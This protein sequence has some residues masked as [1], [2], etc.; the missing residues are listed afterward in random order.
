LIILMRSMMSYIRKYNSR[1]LLSFLL[2]LSVFL[3][4]LTKIVDTDAWLHLSL[5]REIFNQG[6]LP[7]TE[8]LTYPNI[9]KAFSYGSW[10]FGL[11]YYAAY[12]FFD[13]YGVILLKAFSITAAFYFLLKDSLLPYKNHLVSIIILT[14]AVIIARGRFVERPDT[15]LM[16]FLAFSMYALNAF[17]Y[18]NKRYIYALPL[19]HLVWANSHS[20]VILSFAVFLPYIA[21]NI[22]AALFIDSDNDLRARSYSR[23]K[24]ILLIFII[25]FAASLINPVFIKIYTGSTNVIESSWWQDEIVELAKPTWGKQNTPYILAPLLL[26]SFILNWAAIWLII[27]RGKA[28]GMRGAGSRTVAEF[29]LMSLIH[30][31]VILPFIVLSFKAL[32]FIFIL[33]IVSAPIVSRNTSHLFSYLSEQLEFARYRWFVNIIAALTAAWIITYSSL[34]LLRVEPIGEPNRVF[35]FGFNDAIMPEG[36]LNYMDDKNIYGRVFNIFHWGQYISWRDFPKRSAFVDGRGYLPAELLESLA[37]A[38]IRPPVLDKLHEKYGFE[39]VLLDYPRDVTGVTELHYDKDLSLDHPDWALVYW[40]DRSTLYLR[41]GGPYD[42]VIK[43]DEYRFVKPVNNIEGTRPRLNEQDYAEGLVRELKR[44]IDLTGSS[45]AYSYLGF[46][47]NEKGLYAKAIALF[48]KAE[49][50]TEQIYFGLAHAYGSLNNFDESI[51]YYKKAFDL[52]K[53][54][55]IL[56]NIATAYSKKG[57]DDN[58]LKYFLKAI[59]LNERLTYIYPK[60]IQIYKK[61]GMTKEAEEAAKKYEVA[62]AAAKGEEH[63]KI[64][65]KAFFDKKLDTA[66]KEYKISIEI[67]PL[68]PEAYSNLGYIYYDMNMLPQAYEYQRK[69]LDVDPDF[70]NAH[71]GL[72]LIYIK[73]NDPQSAKRHFQKYIESEPSG[74]FSRR[75]KEEI[76]RLK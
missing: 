27:K 50:K 6:G 30:L 52:Y 2:L 41:R 49:N 62:D 4:S 48:E 25:S 56:Y 45:K 51:K 10:L 61:K 60:I 1:H 21:V 31:F 29:F 75:A 70:A 18:E 15:F 44:N 69:A 12:R 32:R 66:A 3:M 73:W 58:A 16:F 74:Y 43:E 76:E 68:N 28:E 42:S 38:R 26:I 19:I 37:L 11:V 34:Y 35:G 71:Y 8:T 59:E 13:V 9:G 65:L 53:D 17:I 7:A 23:F 46:I 72:A 63:F 55:V 20:S 24:V 64:A 5:G 14:A 57:D 36:A 33:G 67:N 54:G 40:D 39:A 22:I 47:Y